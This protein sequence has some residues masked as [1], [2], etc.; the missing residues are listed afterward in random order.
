MKEIQVCNRCV[1]D[2][3]DLDIVFDKQGNCNHCNA[4]LRNDFKINDTKTKQLQKAVKQIKKAGKGKKYDCIIGVS[5]GVDSTYV[6]YAVKELG[7]NPLAVHLDNSWNSEL[8]VANIQKIID[9][10]EIDLYT[11]V[12]DWNEFRDLQMSFLKASTPGMEIPT[13]HAI[14]SI[15]SKVAAKENIKYIINGSNSSSEFIMAKSWSEGIAQ[16]DWLLIKNVLKKFGKVKLKTFPRTSMLNFFYYKLF[17]KQSIVNILNYV[18]FNKT[19]AMKLIQ[20]KLDW[21]YY[22]GKHYESIYTRFTQSYIQPVKFNIDKRKAHHSNLI[23]S[24]ELTREEAIKDLTTNP[25]KDSKML[26]EDK[27]YFIK[28]MRMTRDEFSN[29]M[30]AETKR[31]QDYN[32]YYNHWFYSGLKRIAFKFHTFLKR[33]NYYGETAA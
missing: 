28:K 5:G 11:Y 8:A 23:C 16:R 26:E 13:D 12:I 10:L 22:G 25:Y 3:T 30:N 31:Y 32:G 1:M 33:I 9:K 19:N 17:K 4:Y 21:V 20:D 14:M 15:L 24:G 6:A 7:L 29:I 18:D 27:E 2:T